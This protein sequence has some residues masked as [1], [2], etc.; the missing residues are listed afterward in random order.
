MTVT[1]QSVSQSVIVSCNLSE[2]LKCNFK[3]IHFLHP[4]HV[5]LSWWW[6][7]SVS[8]PRATPA[9]TSVTSTTEPDWSRERGLTKDSPWY[10]NDN[11][12]FD[13]NFVRGFINSA[14]SLSTG[15]HYHCLLLML[16]LMLL[17]LQYSA[18]IAVYC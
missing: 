13:F 18:C 11:S 4:G 8:N 10:K 9:G 14:L 16:L 3:Y 6:S 17:P 15:L 2:R 7:L 5:T 1:S 12:Y